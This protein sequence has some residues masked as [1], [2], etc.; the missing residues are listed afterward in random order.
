MVYA[1]QREFALQRVEA[2]AYLRK[3]WRSTDENKEGEALTGRVEE[4]WRAESSAQRWSFEEQFRGLN[5]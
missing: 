5:V 3:L 1:R 2:N 4:Q